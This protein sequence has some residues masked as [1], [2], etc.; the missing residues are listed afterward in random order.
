MLTIKTSTKTPSFSSIA[1]IGILGLFILGTA[2]CGGGTGSDDSSENENGSKFTEKTALINNLADIMNN[3]YAQLDS[4]TRAFKTSVDAYCA[5]ATSIADTAKRDA[6]QAAFKAAMSDVQ[7]VLLF[8]AK[9]QG[10]G[11]GVTS[12]LRNM[13]VVY[14]WPL[15]DRCEIDKEVAKNSTTVKMPVNKRGMDAMEYLLFVDPSENHSCPTATTSLT[16]FNDSTEANKQLARCGYMKAVVDDLTTTTASLKNAWAS[17]FKASMK[18][19]TDQKATLNKVT[20]GMYY[21]A[22]VGKEEKI[23]RPMGGGRTNTPPSCGAGNVCPQD[24][25]AFYSKTSFE[26]LITNT[27]SFQTLF[28]GGPVADKATNIGFDD[29]IIAKDGNSTFADTMASNIA[30]TLTKLKDFKT[31]GTLQDC[32]V[33]ETCKQELENFYN[34]SFADVTR[35]LRDTMLPKLNLNRP[36]K[37]TAD[38]D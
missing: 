5:D 31:N 8:G 17:S 26:H 15:S 12:E 37:S 25:E 23:D 2:S 24:V 19:S 10:I 11:P 35:G 21:L 4:S 28:F 16:A 14:S 20:D 7:K 13:E 6:A 18:A 9:G 1:K 36:Q 3:G 32:V 29:W 38:A 22:D 27:E 33:D 34:G 30:D